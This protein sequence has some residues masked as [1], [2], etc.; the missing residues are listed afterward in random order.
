MNFNIKM[1]TL[2]FYSYKGGV[3]RS[4]ALANIATRLTE[5]NK[6]I[7]LL[8][9]ELEDPGLHLKIPTLLKTVKIEK[10]IVD[11]SF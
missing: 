1:K 2:T 4:L 3:G 7:G 5:F 9:F 8:Y 6:K 10:G 11:Y